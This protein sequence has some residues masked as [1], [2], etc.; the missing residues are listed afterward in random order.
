[1]GSPFEMKQTCLYLSDAAL[2]LFDFIEAEGVEGPLT[3]LDGVMK[4]K[5]VIETTEEIRAYYSRRNL[6]RML[7]LGISPATLLKNKG[8]SNDG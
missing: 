1:M 8:E 7:A 5:D 3:K 6:S 4:L 2:A